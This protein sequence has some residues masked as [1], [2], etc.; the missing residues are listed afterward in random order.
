[1]LEQAKHA[2]VDPNHVLTRF[3]NERFLYRLSC[4]TQ[5]ER[6]ILNGAMLMVPW[7]G[8][9]LRPT[10]D[11]DLLWLDVLSPAELATVF[12]D[13]CTS[14]TPADGAEFDADSV[15]VR[16]MGRSAPLGSVRVV[17]DGWLGASRGELLVARWRPPGGWIE[18]EERGHAD[19]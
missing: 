17:V 18:D 3:A 1:M 2:R 13:A 11:A 7:I 5:R 4:S 14:A 16:E 10:R 19:V 9:G 8:E 12:E 6:F 15:P